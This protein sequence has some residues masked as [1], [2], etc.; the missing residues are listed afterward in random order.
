VIWSAPVVGD[1]DGDGRPEIVFGTGTYYAVPQT[2]HLVYAVH[3]DGTTVAGWPVHVDGQVSTTPALGDLDNDGLVDVVVTDDNTGPSHTFH[4]YAFKGNGTL[5]WSR[6]PKGYF[7]ETLSA[8]DPVIADVL[9]GGPGTG[10]EVLVTENAEI[11][12]FDAGGTQLTGSGSGGF[13]FYAASTVNGVAVDVSGSTVEIVTTSDIGGSLTVSAWKG[14]GST[15]QV[16]WGM[17]HHDAAANG[18]APNA[19]ICA[20]RAPVATT[21]HPLTPCR[22]FDTRDTPKPLGGPALQSLAARSFNVGGVCGIP[23]NAVA[24]S[25]NMTVTNV[26]ASGELVV[27]PSDVARPGTSA[28]SFRPSKT[29]ANNAI[30]YL[31]ATTDMFSVYNNCVGTVDLIVDVNGYFQ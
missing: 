18:A 8:G 19:G 14:T 30:V 31:T 10:K 11:V 29:R 25:V 21:L 13:H 7:G 17:F 27:F 24:I 22:L 2:S 4:V 1:I 26:T 16:P 3:C 6:Q 28:I 12:V 15:T 5:L 20:P 23:A 9:A